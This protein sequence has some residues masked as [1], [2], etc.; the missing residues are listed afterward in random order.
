MNRMY[1]ALK[2]SWGGTTGIRPLLGVCYTQCSR[3]KELCEDWWHYSEQLIRFQ[4]PAARLSAFRGNGGDV[5]TRTSVSTVKCFLP[6]RNSQLWIA[7]LEV[8]PRHA[9]KEDKR[10]KHPTALSLALYH[11]TV[12]GGVGKRNN[13]LKTVSHSHFDKNFRA[14]VQFSNIW[15]AWLRFLCDLFILFVKFLQNWIVQPSFFQ[16]VAQIPTYQKLFNISAWYQTRYFPV[17][18]SGSFYQSKPNDTLFFFSSFL[19]Y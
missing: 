14:L 18:L 17:C 1:T 8:H 4:T 5:C 3:T 15:C 11:P 13:H 16:L 7:S 9:G 19:P 6:A 10:P 2:W 12:M